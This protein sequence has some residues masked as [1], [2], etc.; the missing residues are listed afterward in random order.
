MAP[1]MVLIVFVGT[2]YTVS[3]P[4]Q[5][6]IM[7]TNSTDDSGSN[8]FRLRSIH[9]MR[10]PQTIPRQNIGSMKFRLTISHPGIRIIRAVAVSDAVMSFLTSL[11]RGLQTGQC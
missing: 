3:L 6:N 9:S 8:Q 2:I 11:H 4:D 7:V 10:L 5:K 1:G